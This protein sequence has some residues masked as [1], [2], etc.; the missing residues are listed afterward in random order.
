MRYYVITK[1]V[2]EKTLFLY[3]VGSQYLKSVFTENM[4]YITSNK[5]E[6]DAKF[7]KLIELGENV[8]IIELH[9]VVFKGN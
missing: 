3:S 7:K 2:N 8:S 6:I 1:V 4:T 9:V 5:E